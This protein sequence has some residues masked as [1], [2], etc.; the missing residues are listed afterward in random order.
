VISE[1]EKQVSYKGSAAT[2]FH[3][4]Y[5]GGFP[6]GEYDIELFLNGMPVGSRRVRVQP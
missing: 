1:P 2:E 5:S 4:E 6:P 3:I